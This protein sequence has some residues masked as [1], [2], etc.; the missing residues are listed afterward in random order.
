MGE[1]AE[2]AR[3]EVAGELGDL[4]DGIWDG[5]EEVDVGW[6]VGRGGRAGRGEGGER[7]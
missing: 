3:G 6:V 2:A 1:E 7:F 5:G 4:V